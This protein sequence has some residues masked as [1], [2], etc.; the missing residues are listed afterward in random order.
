MTASTTPRLGL[1]L[2]SGS[3]SYNISDFDDTF[4]ILDGK[5]G[6]APVANY[7]ALPST[8][9]TAQ[10]GSVYLQ[11]DNKSLWMWN[12]PGAGAGTWVK[13]NTVGLISSVTQASIVST[14]TTDPS[15]APSMVN[16][17]FQVPGGRAVLILFEHPRISNDGTY[18]YSVC[19]MWRDGVDIVDSV[20]SGGASNKDVS[21]AL[22]RVLSAGSLGA[23]GTT[24]NI[25]VTVRSSTY[26]G[27][28]TT[29][30]AA[31]QL[32]IIEI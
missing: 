23:P 4:T 5:P 17:N 30:N 11:L 29:A 1:M 15:S 31:G 9:T 26:G 20:Q 8:L 7:A 3:D 13:L 19:E 6:I 18:G 25:K 2:P 32:Y 10:H 24:V 27:G 14:S 21:H 12:K 16:T 28:T 22:M